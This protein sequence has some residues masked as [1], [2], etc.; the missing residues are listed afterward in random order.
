MVGGAQAVHLHTGQA[1]FALAPFTK[2]AD[3][4]LDPRS[5]MDNPTVDAEMRA[6]GFVLDATK[7]KPGA[8][9]SPRGVPVDLM[10]PEALAGPAA[11]GRRGGRIPPHS[12]RATRRAAGLEAAVV[13]HDL[14]E[15]VG[16]KGDARRRTA[17]VAGP[18]ALLVAK[19]HKLGERQMRRRGEVRSGSILVR[20]R[21]T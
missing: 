13:D 3:L 5:L 20:S 18:A 21:L 11:P 6:A 7:G 8:W 4:V 15:I 10:V 17:N 1:E 19:L 9:L 14:L 2:D 12:N 16:L